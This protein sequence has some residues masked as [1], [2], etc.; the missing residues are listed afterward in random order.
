MDARKPGWQEIRI[1][2]KSNQVY[3]FEVPFADEMCGI[4]T[5]EK[6]TFVVVEKTRTH[7]KLYYKKRCKPTFLIAGRT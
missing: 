3:T 5:S 6:L 4:Y 7:I 2:L 1:Q